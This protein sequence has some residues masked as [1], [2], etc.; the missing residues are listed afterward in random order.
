MCLFFS[1]LLLF[2]VVPQAWSASIT[3][4]PSA[5]TV[6][7][8]DPVSF[9]VM[10]WSFPLISAYDFTVRFDASELDGGTWTDATGFTAF[11]ADPIVTDPGTGGAGTINGTIDDISYGSFSSFLSGD[12]LLG[13]IGFTAPTPVT[14]SFFDVFVDF[15]GFGDDILDDFGLQI[16]NSIDI[17]GAEAIVNPA[18]VIPEP[19]SILLIGSGLLGIIGFARKTNRR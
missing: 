4:S 19:S 18:T 10:V 17:N 5:V 16:T 14:D 11:I 13:T 12:F 8:G 7:P 6:G 9:D 1:T 3:L 2:A 15:S